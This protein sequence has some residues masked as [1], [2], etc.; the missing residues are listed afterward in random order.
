[1]PG[2]LLIGDFDF[3]S[4][5]REQLLICGVLLVARSADNPGPDRPSKAK[6]SLRS[7]LSRACNVGA[8]ITLKVVWHSHGLELHQPSSNRFDKC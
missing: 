7:S 8:P 6:T 1:M 2:L 5:D 4:P 3:N